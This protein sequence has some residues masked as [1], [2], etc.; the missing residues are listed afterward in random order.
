MSHRVSVHLRNFKRWMRAKLS[1]FF[2]SWSFTAS[3]AYFISSDRKEK[4]ALRSS[5][6]LKSAKEKEVI[7]ADD[8]NSCHSPLRRQGLAMATLPF[9]LYPKVTRAETS[10]FRSSVFTQALR[11]EPT[12]SVIQSSSRN[13][14]LLETCDPPKT[15]EELMI[16]TLPV[17]NP[18]FRSLAVQI[19]GTVD[20]GLLGNVVVDLDNKRSQLEPA[21]NPDDNAM[22]QISKGEN[23]ERLIEEFRSA[24]V[25]WEN[26]TN[27]ATES[28][29]RT[30]LQTLAA[31]GELLVADYPYSV[32]ETGKYSYLPRL[33]GRARVIFQMKKANGSFYS[34]RLLVDGYI[35]PLTAGNFVDLVQ[36][37]FYNGLPLR[38]SKKRFGLG[39]AFDVVSVPILGAFQEGFYD[40]LT[41]KPRRIPL[42]VLQQD[43]TRQVV[44]THDSN[45]DSTVSES[46]SLLPVVTDINSRTILMNHPSDKWNGASSEF[47]FGDEEFPVGQYAPFAYVLSDEKIVV[48]QGDRIES[49]V[50]EDTSCNLVKLRESNFS[51]VLRGPRRQ[52]R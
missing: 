47:V 7:H 20:R 51:E 13:L 31:V 5:K 8:E 26:A 48:E 6:A 23:T 34:F 40:P 19:M 41:A 14:T 30:A 25:S 42:E 3:T 52:D 28:Y 50:V 21:F 16:M 12:F 4:L 1:L 38:T 32:P 35:A 18:L 10:F 33:L 37:Q 24:I 17:K 39:N 27:L 11:E 15:L 36:R 43:I 44:L 22:L 49:A 29:R 46:I 2:L 45:F 9:I